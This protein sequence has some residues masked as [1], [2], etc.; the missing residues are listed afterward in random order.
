MGHPYWPLLDLRVVTPRLEV[1]LPTVDEVTQLA[2]LS[3]DVHDAEEMPFGKPWTDA[4]D[5][6]AGTMRWYW[7]SLGVWEPT[8]WRYNPAVFVDG[9]PVGSQG[10]WADDFCVLRAVETGSWLAR[11]GPVYVI[12]VVASHLTSSPPVFLR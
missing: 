10:V 8:S 12:A 6:E 4:P 1:R 2:G 9:R 3:R 5:V 7:R 11:P